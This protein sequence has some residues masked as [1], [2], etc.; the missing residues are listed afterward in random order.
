M[1]T[2]F[3]VESWHEVDACEPIPRH[4]AVRV[5]GWLSRCN[6]SHQKQLPLQ[7]PRHWSKRDPQDADWLIWVGPHK[8]T[9]P[10]D[11][12]YPH[13]HLP[14]WCRWILI[15]TPS[16]WHVVPWDNFWIE[17]RRIVREDLN[18]VLPELPSLT[19]I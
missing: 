2:D 14:D 16:Q 18:L 19:P 10:R 11:A 6:Q 4:V 9:Q 1:A 3:K 17:R 7:P 8:M 15:Q 5:G 12:G 13:R